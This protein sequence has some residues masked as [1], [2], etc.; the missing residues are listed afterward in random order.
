[1]SFKMIDVSSNNHEGGAPI[2]WVTV[3]TAGVRGVMIKATEGESYVNPW[4]VTDAHGAVAAG[5]HVGYYHY[6]RPGESAPEAQANNCWQHVKD[7]PRDLGISLDL[8]VAEA[9]P[10][11]GLDRFAMAFLGGPGG[12]PSQVATKTLYTDE[13]FA[14]NLPMTVKAYPLWFASWGKRPRRHVWAWQRGQ[15]DMAGV[16][17]AVDYGTYFG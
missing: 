14:S 6:A 4:L 8:E 11:V 10:W 7:L 17:G 2:D 12:L 9:M 5:L 15:H 16:I 13:T 3:H 1:M